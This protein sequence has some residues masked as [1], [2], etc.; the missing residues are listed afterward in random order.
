MLEPKDFVKKIRDENKALFEAS[1]MNVKEYFEG[2]LPEEEMV[3]RFI[4]RMVNERMNMTE[5]SV[6]SISSRR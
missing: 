4:G 5:I 6:P 2:N 1:K 3:D